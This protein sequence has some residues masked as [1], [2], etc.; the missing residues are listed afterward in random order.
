[1]KALPWGRDAT[2]TGGQG[3]DVCVSVNVMNVRLMEASVYPDEQ[4]LKFTTD[5]GNLAHSQIL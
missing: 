3:V 5:L 1:M 4:P 2:T